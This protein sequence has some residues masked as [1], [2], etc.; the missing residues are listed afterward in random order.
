MR[1]QFEAGDSRQFTWVSSVAPDAAPILKV[2]GL[3]GTIINSITA[4]Q[5]DT[6]HFFALFTM[7]TSE[8]VYMGEWYAEKTV[9][10]SAYPFVSRFLF[11]VA[12][13]TR[14]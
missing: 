5:S 11:N 14:S 9:V 7:P 8:G 1:E 10:S 2:T 12:Q 3:A 13:T 4:Q 6:T